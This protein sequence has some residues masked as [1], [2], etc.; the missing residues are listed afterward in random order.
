VS[1]RE[2]LIPPND[3]RFEGAQFISDE[4]RRSY[5]VERSPYLHGAVW[6]WAQWNER[7]A[8]RYNPETGEES[9]DVWDHDHCHF[10]HKTAFSERYEHDLRE[11]WTT[12]GPMGQPASERQPDYHW[13]CPTCF[14]RLREQFK[15][16]TAP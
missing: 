13:V 6:R 3:P 10:C 9:D 11:G 14:E 16:T 4:A 8:T 1:G 12:A 7:P 5:T 15:W 2:E